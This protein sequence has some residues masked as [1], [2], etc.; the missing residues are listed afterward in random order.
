MTKLSRTLP[1]TAAALAAATV[2]SPVTAS[3]QTYNPSGFD[4]YDACK[5]RD[6]NNQ[7]VGGLI[8]A[9][10]GGVIGSQVA[11]VGARSEGSALGA[12]L[13]AA[14][15][16]GIADDNRNC[17]TEEARASR[18]GYQQT[19]PVYNTPP[20]YQRSDNQSVYST[21]AHPKRTTAKVY[22]AKTVYTS[23]RIYSGAPGNR[24]YQGSGPYS[25][26]PA[27]TYRQDRSYNHRKGY[28]EVDRINREIESLRAES[29]RLKD[30]RR[31][32]SA[33]WIDRRLDE[34][35]YSL[36]ELKDRKRRV[37]RRIKNN[38][39]RGYSAN[40]NTGPRHYHG[41]DTCNFRH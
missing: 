34:I 26:S 6:K 2:I 13:G 9:V 29:R 22:N 33:P 31:Y 27:V 11:A 30:R 38:R 1:L 21:P 37:K 14:A 8:G 10:A 19:D 39:R 40:Y 35:G 16:A 36:G 17:R 25:A 15:G 5:K 18:V 32:A 12:V 23:P 4:H 24:T 20:A 41:S 3:A 28:S 7:L